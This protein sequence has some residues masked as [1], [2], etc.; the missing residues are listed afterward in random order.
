MARGET[1]EEILAS[2]F[3]KLDLCISLE[4]QS[5]ELTREDI[6]LNKKILEKMTDLEFS[7]RGVIENRERHPK[8]GSW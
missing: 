1:A 3:E 7:V 4:K 6:A 5:I 8:R 2:I